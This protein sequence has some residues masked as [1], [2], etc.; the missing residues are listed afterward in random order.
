MGELR[1]TIAGPAAGTLAGDST[2]F[3]QFA[4]LSG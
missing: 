4:A 2:G 3:A 1:R